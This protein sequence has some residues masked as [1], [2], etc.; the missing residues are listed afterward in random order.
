MKKFKDLSKVIGLVGRGGR[1]FPSNE[2]S[3]EKLHQV[4]DAAGVPKPYAVTYG[5]EELKLIKQLVGAAG[6]G[7]MVIERGLN[8]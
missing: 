1:F 2:R 7:L 3:E 4:F 6:F 5:R 8:R